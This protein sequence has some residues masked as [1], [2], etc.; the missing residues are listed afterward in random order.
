MKLFILSSFILFSFGREVVD[1]NRSQLSDTQ[2]EVIRA[3]IDQTNVCG[4][5][6]SPYDRL[7][8]ACNIFYGQRRPSAPHRIT[9]IAPDVSSSEVHFYLKKI[10]QKKY[11][12][13]LAGYH[14][15]YKYRVNRV[16][17]PYTQIFVMIEEDKGWSVDEDKTSSRMI[18]SDEWDI[19]DALYLW[20]GMTSDEL[21]ESI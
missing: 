12:V 6:T 15:S 16:V 8:R 14:Y 7:K 5:S 20:S 11:E 2:R 4:Q 19:A 21:L 10:D 9:E 3:F 13:F 17:L 1:V 18:H